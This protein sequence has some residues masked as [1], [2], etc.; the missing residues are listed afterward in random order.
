[1][2]VPKV[3]PLQGAK[4]CVFLR[5][6]GVPLL[7]PHSIVISLIIIMSFLVYLYLF[8]WKSG[9]LGFGVPHLSVPCFCL[10][11]FGPLFVVKNNKLK[12]QAER[13]LRQCN[14]H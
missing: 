3:K 5:L 13:S 2:G 7:C 8:D 14:L 4:G 9:F 6:G 1:M 12:S 11:N 10:V